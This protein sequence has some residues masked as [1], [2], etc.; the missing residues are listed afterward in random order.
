MGLCKTHF[1][2]QHNQVPPHHMLPLLRIVRLPPIE[3]R[4]AEP[5]LSAEHQHVDQAGDDGR[6][7]ER[8][9][10]QG[11][12]QRAGERQTAVAAGFH[13]QEGGVE[14]GQG[15][16]DPGDNGPYGR[17]GGGGPVHVKQGI[18]IERIDSD[19]LVSAHGAAI[20]LKDP[21]NGADK[22]VGDTLRAA[23]AEHK[24][25][26]V[27]HAQ[28]SKHAQQSFQSGLCGFSA[29]QV[30]D[31]GKQAQRR[32]QQRL[33]LDEHGERKGCKG[34]NVFFLGSL[35]GAQGDQQR[36]YG[37]NLA[38]G[39]GIDDGGRIKCIQQGKACGNAGMQ[40]FFFC[41]APDEHCAQQIAQDGDQLQK[42]NVLKLQA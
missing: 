41:A 33:R 11:D 35:E 32:K 23:D 18:E 2:S 9:V 28:R 36:K 27:D 21:G 8:Q 10:D 29:D 19:I 38:P 39:G 16:Q 37:V 17:I 30:D 40:P 24:G 26:S 14:I 5:A 7:R 25:C 13:I 6:H 15:E 4:P 42:H 20:Q 1:L 22:G 31:D 3:Q 12:Q 34:R